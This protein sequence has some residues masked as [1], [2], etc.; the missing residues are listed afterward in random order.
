MNENYSLRYEPSGLR[1]ILSYIDACLR[2]TVRHELLKATS[3]RI[4]PLGATVLDSMRRSWRW[5]RHRRHHRQ[6]YPWIFHNSQKGPIES[7]AHVV[8][9]FQPT[10]IAKLSEEE[11]AQR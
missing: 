10:K 5:W 1:M 9:V 6:R 8:H 7:F 2:Y 3:T 4:R 11:H